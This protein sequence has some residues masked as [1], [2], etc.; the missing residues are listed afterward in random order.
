MSSILRS[1]KE[2]RDMRKELRQSIADG[3]FGRFP[4]DDVT[5][6][7]T[8]QDLRTEPT[9]PFIQLVMPGYERTLH[10]APHDWAADPLI[11]SADPVAYEPLSAADCQI[12]VLTLLAAGESGGSGD[13]SAPIR[14]ELETVSLLAPAVEGYTALSYMWG[15]VEGEARTIAVDGRRFRA[16]PNLHAALRQLRSKGHRRLWIDAVCINQED[17]EERSQQV[18]QMRSIYARAAKTLVWLGPESDTSNLAMHLLNV[19]SAPGD[20]GMGQKRC[21]REAVKGR[22]LPEVREVDGDDE[23]RQQHQQ[24]QQRTMGAPSNGLDQGLYADAWLAFDQLFDREYWRR[25]W[26]IQEITVSR[27]IDIMCGSETI[28]WKKLEMAFWGGP[29]KGLNPMFDPTVGVDF[30]RAP[31]RTGEM[32]DFWGWRKAI[33]GG[34]PKALLKAM[35]D[36]GSSK[37]TDPRDHIYALLGITMDGSILVPVPN[38]ALPVA[39]VFTSL[40]TSMIDAS[41]NIDLICLQPRSGKK[42]TAGLPSWVPDWADLADVD[43]P[44]AHKMALTPGNKLRDPNIQL[45]NTISEGGYR[46]LT[47]NGM[48]SCSGRLYDIIDGL[49]GTLSADGKPMDGEHMGMVQPDNPTTCYP[50]VLATAEAIQQS[51]HQLLDWTREVAGR[52]CADVLSSCWLE[53]RGL[54]PLLRTKHAAL[55]RWL[56]ANR[57]F[58][59]GSV[60]LG[61]W[62]DMHHGG[63]KGLINRVRTQSRTA[64]RQLLFEQRADRWMGEA[65]AV[66]KSGMRLMTTARGRV[67]MAHPQARKGDHVCFMEGMGTFVILRPY[68]GTAEEKAHREAV[69]QELRSQRYASGLTAET[70]FSGGY[71][72]VGEAYVKTLVDKKTGVEDYSPCTFFTFFIH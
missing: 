68:D 30:S 13:A 56:E 24:H 50:G 29:D 60:E 62:L 20:F 7:P 22:Y 36:C 10:E 26:I 19:L 16:T 51:L 35:L 12:R 40:A 2:L 71:Q 57:D 23:Q 49:S 58:V 44:Y 11:T 43:R 70:R 64:A 8:A 39:E 1:I 72:V 42:K 45:F 48:L 3:T 31:R 66:L 55:G 53:D 17:R 37:A 34:Q 25:M 4:D 21:Y 33:A 59:V 52:D 67:G 15:G 54:L 38:Y 65:E 63:Y 5:S 18:L 61:R 46:I 28:S 41:G 32:F 47:K 69:E 6:V 9:N 14:C 27:E